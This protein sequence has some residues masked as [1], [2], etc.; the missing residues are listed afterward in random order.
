[1]MT[2]S[3]MFPQI[4]GVHLDLGS[5]LDMLLTECTF[6]VNSPENQWLSSSDETLKWHVFHKIFNQ[7]CSLQKMVLKEYD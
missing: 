1:M 3:F 5:S 2:A 4:D 6:S 7:E